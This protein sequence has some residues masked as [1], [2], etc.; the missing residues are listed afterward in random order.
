MYYWGHSYLAIFYA[1]GL[2][3]ILLNKGSNSLAILRGNKLQFF[4]KISYSVYLFHPM[5]IGLFFLSKGR[6]ES[7]RNIDDAALLIAAFIT[8]LAFC[9]ISYRFLEEPLIA[10]GTPHSL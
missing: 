8:T 9:W 3:G 1:I 4:G 2:I 10:W 7:L 6:T 5:I